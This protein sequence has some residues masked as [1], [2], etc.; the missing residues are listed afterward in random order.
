MKTDFNT[1]FSVKVVDGIGNLNA[2]DNQVRALK[3]EW[4]DHHP[5]IIQFLALFVMKNCPDNDN[6]NNGIYKRWFSCRQT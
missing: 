4:L 1:E 2:Y 3:K 5:R 6:N